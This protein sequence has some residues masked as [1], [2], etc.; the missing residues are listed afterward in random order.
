ME[1][2]KSEATQILEE[3][4]FP[5][6]KWESNLGRLESGGM[7]SPSKIPGLSWDKQ[8]DT[9]ELIMRRFTEEEPVTKKSII[10]K[11]SSIYDPLG[12]LSPTTVEGKQIY[13]EACD[14]MRGWTNEISDPPRKEWTKLTKQLK[15][16][17]VPRTNGET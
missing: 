13:R 2:F 10:S 7:T 4:R 17:T 12:M 9:L 14:E 1:R 15:N 16:V 6:H 5:V 8:N 3:A 11:L